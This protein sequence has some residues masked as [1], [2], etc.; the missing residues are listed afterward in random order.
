M[1]IQEEMRRV[2]KLYKKR[3]II[4]ILYVL[5]CPAE[6]TDC[7]PAEYDDYYDQ[8]ESMIC[9]RLSRSFVSGDFSF[10]DLLTASIQRGK[11]YQI[12]LSN[13]QKTAQVFQ[14]RY[15]KKKY[16]PSGSHLSF[17]KLM[18]E[19]N[20]KAEL[21]K[22]VLLSGGQTGQQI[23]KLGNL[24]AETEKN[25]NLLLNQ[26]N[27]SEKLCREAAGALEEAKETNRNMLSTVLTDL[28]LFAAII[29]AAVA[30]YLNGIVDRMTLSLPMSRQ[31]FL[32]SL[33]WHA[34]FLLIFFLIFLVGKLTGRS[35]A[36]KSGCP[37]ERCTDC[38][39]KCSQFGQLWRRFPWLV[40]M[41]AAFLAVELT[42]LF[43]IIWQ[44][45]GWGWGIFSILAICGLPL[46]PVYLWKHKYI[47]KFFKKIS[48]K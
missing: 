20:K 18:E 41:N 6:E 33:R 10:D 11:S 45:S 25:Q 1:N 39:E 36:S 30:V 21:F 22:T 5:S 28:G 48:G 42:A 12:I 8:L 13:I 4:G 27:Q 35:L 24:L 7:P 44:T 46:L 14:S 31:L 29:I 38:G 9:E 17:L 19:I 47:Q 43:V 34:T 26:I 32:S 40:L 2:D 37:S 16:A 15:E 3:R 23:D